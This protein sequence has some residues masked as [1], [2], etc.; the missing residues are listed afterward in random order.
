MTR[1]APPAPRPPPHTQTLSASRVQS[2]KREARERGRVSAAPGGE[3]SERRAGAD[4]RTARP[5]RLPSCSQ[6]RSPGSHAGPRRKPRGPKALRSPRPIRRRPPAGGC[7]PGPP[8]CPSVTYRA[9]A[10]RGSPA[11]PASDSSLASHPGRGRRRHPRGGLGAG[12]RRRDVCGA[13]PD[14]A[15]PTAA[16]RPRRPAS[17]PRGGEGALQGADPRPGSRGLTV[18]QPQDWQFPAFP[19]GRKFCF[20][21]PVLLK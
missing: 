7:S 16:P 5:R 8:R 13:G 11:R 2:P 9:E 12:P 19:P 14:A 10:Q 1:R 3:R 6:P 21:F 20:P 18:G 4:P 15:P 17:R